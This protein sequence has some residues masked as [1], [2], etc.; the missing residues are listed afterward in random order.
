MNIADYTVTEAGFGSDLGAEKFLDIVCHNS[1]LKP[2]VVVLVASIRSLKM[3]GGLTLK[4][5][6]N[7]NMSCLHKGLENLEQHIQNIKHF[8]LPCVIAINKFHTDTKQ[9]ID[10]IIKFAKSQ[11]V[12]CSISTVFVDGSKGAI[13][14]AKKVI[15]KC[16]SKSLLIPVYSLNDKL[17]T[18]INKIVTRC[19]G[20]SGVEYSEKAK[21]KLKQ[22]NNCK[23]YVCMAKTPLTFSDNPKEI[24]VQK[25]FVIHVEDLLVVNGVNFIVVISGNIFRMP[26]LPKVPAACKDF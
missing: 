8:G 7:V 12:D 26:G 4:E 24:I 9:E 6:T 25:P 21:L 10:E 14:L 19:Y 23:A 1:H 22:L 2:N 11:S 13:D 18:K 20:A 16:K 5:L 3:H 17:T 15:G